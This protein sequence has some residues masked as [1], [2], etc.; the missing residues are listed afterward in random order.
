MPVAMRPT[1]RQGKAKSSMKG[2]K[3]AVKKSRAMKTWKVL[4]DEEILFARKRYAKEKLKPSV[5]AKRLG[6]DKSAMTVWVVHLHRTQ[7]PPASCWC[8]TQAACVSRLTSASRCVKGI[9]VETIKSK[10]HSIV[11]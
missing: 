5:I 1:L 11:H 3:G 10:Q 9:E 6:R 2:V 8:T 7:F 4:N